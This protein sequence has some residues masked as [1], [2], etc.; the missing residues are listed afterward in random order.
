V[1]ASLTQIEITSKPLRMPARTEAGVA[2]GTRGAH[3][4]TAV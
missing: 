3:G 4:V 1:N 2:T